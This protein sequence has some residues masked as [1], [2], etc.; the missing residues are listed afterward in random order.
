MID[1]SSTSKKWGLKQSITLLRILVGWHFLYEGIVK[2]YNPEWTSFG[3]LA[4]AQGPFRPIFQAMASEALLPWV[5][6][7]NWGALVF[8]GIT[9]ILGIFEKAGALVG[10]GLLLLYYLAHPSWPGMAQIN[11]EGSY[12]IVN[13]NLIEAVVCLVLFYC[14]TGAVFGLSRFFS[15]NKANTKTELT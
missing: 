4:T 14:P 12:W 2:V 6:T 7:L 3:Y 5:D 13:K 8:V 1:M 10:A 11:T 9:L 15:K